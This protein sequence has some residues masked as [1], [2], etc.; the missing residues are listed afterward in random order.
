MAPLLLNYDLRIFD[1]HDTVG[2]CISALQ[3][4]GFDTAHL[5]DGYG[6]ALDF[7]MDGVIDSIAQLNVQLTRPIAV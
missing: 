2:K 5:H 6:L 7:V 3:A 1:A 4:M